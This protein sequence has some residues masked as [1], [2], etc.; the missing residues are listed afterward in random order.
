MA[1]LRMMTAEEFQNLDH[2]RTLAAELK[3]IDEER[4]TLLSEMYDSILKL[5]KNYRFDWLRMNCGS[6][7]Q[8]YII[9]SCQKHIPELMKEA[10]K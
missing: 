3:R 5:D 9:E 1:Q 8:K 7:T 6:V 10:E 4:A 2:V